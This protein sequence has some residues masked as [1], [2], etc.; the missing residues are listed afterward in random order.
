MKKYFFIIIICCIT[1]F[2]CKTRSQSNIKKKKIL[3]GHWKL[4]T[5]AA[6][7][8]MMRGGR[9]EIHWVFRKNNSGLFYYYIIDY[10]TGTE[11]SRTNKDFKYK[12][13][14]DEIE[15]IWNTTKKK[16]IMSYSF[17]ENNGLLVISSRSIQRKTYVFQRVNRIQ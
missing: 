15:I 14:N 13:F 16:D 9:Q 12:I 2:G 3:I 11:E 10:S 6:D 8:R 5:T 17:Q 1:A 7:R 4:Y